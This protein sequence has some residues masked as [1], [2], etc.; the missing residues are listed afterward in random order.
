MVAK[1]LKFSKATETRLLS[2][3][4]TCRSA[5]EALFSNPLSGMSEFHCT[6]ASLRLG[7]DQASVD[8]YR[9]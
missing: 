7:I 2:A 1:L 8:L 9:G 6:L 5:A 4:A 3:R